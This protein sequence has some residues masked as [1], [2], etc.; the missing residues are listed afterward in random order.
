ML[1][2]SMHGWDI[3]MADPVVQERILG[4]KN[5]LGMKGP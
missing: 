1:A 4:A 3:P 2:G 5:N